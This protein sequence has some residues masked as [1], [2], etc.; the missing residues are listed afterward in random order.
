MLRIWAKAQKSKTRESTE[1]KNHFIGDPDISLAVK[2]TE[3][4]S[5]YYSSK[6]RKI[7][8]NILKYKEFY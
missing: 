4:I 3:R 1:N 8:R 7:W 6:Y 2:D 5:L